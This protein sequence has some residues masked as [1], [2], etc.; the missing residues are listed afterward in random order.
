[1]EYRKIKGIKHY[2]FR[3]IDEFLGFFTSEGREA[4]P[5]VTDWR[6][7]LQGDWVQAEDGGIVQ[8]LKHGVFSNGETWVRTV[9]GTFKQ[10]ERYLMDTDF[11]L[12]GDRYSISGLNHSQVMKRLRERK[13][14]TKSE[15]L[16]IVALVSGMHPKEAW[17]FAF[18]KSLKWREKLLERLSYPR[19][20]ENLRKSVEESAE[21][22]GI[23]VEYLMGQLKNLVE[24]SSNDGVR[25]GAVR[26]LAD[27][28]GVKPG[29]TKAL[30]GP[31]FAQFEIIDDDEVKQIEQEKFKALSGE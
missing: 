18:G 2:V 30:D 26:E 14:L 24:D 16:L 10:S 5:L 1:M 21:N 12:H 11:S 23:T 7:A 19:V 27:W 4:P 29:R 22:L 13:T 25:L 3:D 20:M 17:E 15:K 9:V 31:S 28:I 8:I 6:E